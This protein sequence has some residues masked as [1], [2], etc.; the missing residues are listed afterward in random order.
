MGLYDFGELPPNMAGSS[1]YVGEKIGSPIQSRTTAL[2]MNSPATQSRTLNLEPRIHTN[3]PLTSDAAST[4]GPEVETP[5]SVREAILR[6]LLY[7]D[8]WSHP[9][10]LPEIELF[11]PLPLGERALFRSALAAMSESGEVM[12][13]DGHFF[14]RHR[15]ND[16]VSERKRREERARTFWILSRLSM[17]VIKR[18]PFVRAVMVSGELSK[19]VAG[20]ESDVDFFI[21]TEPD[22]LW[23]TRSLLIFFK[24]VFLLNSKKFFCL[25]YF[26]CTDSLAEEEHNV[27]VASEVAHVKP[28]YN[29][30]LYREY[31]EANRWIYTF[32]PNYD[33]ARLPSPR[34]NERRS[35]MQLVF[36]TLLSLFPLDR[37]DQSL[38][39][40][41]QKVWAR[42]YPEVGAPRLERAFT[43]TATTSRAYVY[44][45]CP[46]VLEAYRNKLSMYGLH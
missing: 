19:N 15:P 6:T 32:F 17:H 27:Y 2:G 38:Q 39:R 14:P 25:N 33:H 11:L 7:Y 46:K 45:F 40:F 36:E 1:L 24:K 20:P 9:L 13:R 31:L 44:D 18:F 30:R 43:T 28:L 5:M 12:E 16:V 4:L 37:F 26:A 42:R 3:L 22:R 29:A 34:V 8:I 10:T 35:L 23:L 41:W 21:L